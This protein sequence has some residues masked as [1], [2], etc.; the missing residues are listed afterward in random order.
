MAGLKC[1]YCGESI[2]Y[3]GTPNGIEHTVFPVKNWEKLVSTVYDA[4][5]RKWQ[6]TPV[7]CLENPRDG[8]AWWAAVY[9]SHR[10]GQD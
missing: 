4:W 10:V 5:R 2:R 8:G 3:H 9:G 7:S 1:S 6:P